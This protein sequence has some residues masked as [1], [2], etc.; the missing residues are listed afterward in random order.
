MAK[1]LPA[2]TLVNRRTKKTTHKRLVKCN[3][4]RRTASFSGLEMVTILTIDMDKGLP[5]VTPTR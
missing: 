3:Q 1:W 2:S 5:A 4:V